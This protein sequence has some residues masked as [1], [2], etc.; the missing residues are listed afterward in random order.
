[1]GFIFVEDKKQNLNNNSSRQVGPWWAG[2]V[3]IMGDVSTWIV[4]P[5]VLALIVG[6]A[7]DNHYHTK[8]TL[9]LI[10]VGVGFLFTCYGIWKTMK[11]YTK[12]LKET[13]NQK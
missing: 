2:A 1:M 6:K 13:E 7:L 5:I 10:C 9:F 11:D 3:R 4:V 8:P 12:K